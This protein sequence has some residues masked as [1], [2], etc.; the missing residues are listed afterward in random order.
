MSMQ[1]K[2]DM[3][4]LVST[5]FALLEELVETGQLDPE[6]FDQRRLR[7][8]DREE[9]RLKERPHVQLTDPVDKYALK[10]LPDIDCEARLHLCKARCCK[11]AF[12]L[13][14]Q[15]LDERIIQW[16]Y[17]KPYMIRQK[18]DGYCVH[19]ERDRKCCSVYENRPATCRAYDCRQ[20][21][22]IWIDFE[23]RI[24]A[25]DSALMDET[26]QPKPD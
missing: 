15:D 23:N 1:T 7:L 25:P 12:P 24:P 22:R 11:L 17:S 9:A 26:L 13:S 14:F 19:M 10:D 8:Q 6:R 20:D 16:D 3:V 21:K 18:P 4:D 2:L 5:L